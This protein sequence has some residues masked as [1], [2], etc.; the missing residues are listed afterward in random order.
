MTTSAGS[1]LNGLPERAD[2]IGTLMTEIAQREQE[3]SAL[4]EKGLND[5]RKEV[6]PQ[7]SC[8][9]SCSV[10]TARTV[11]SLAWVVAATSFSRHHTV[12]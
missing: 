7:R 12:P 3:V 11:T 1:Q 2:G 8:L 5:L 4:R 10:V 6:R 9:L